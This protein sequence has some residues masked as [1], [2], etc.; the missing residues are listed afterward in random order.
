MSYFL[1]YWWRIDKSFAFSLQ[2]KKDEMNLTREKEEFEEDILILKRELVKAEELRMRLENFTT[3][4]ERSLSASTTENEEMKE[5]IENL[6]EVFI[7]WFN[8]VLFDKRWNVMNE[9]MAI[10]FRK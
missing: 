8:A 9:W 5:Q 6:M 7:S 10:W 1:F 4:L 2:A 3:S